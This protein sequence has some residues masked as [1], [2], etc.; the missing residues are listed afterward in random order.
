MGTG[1]IVFH[2]GLGLTAPLLTWESILLK[3]LVKVRAK[4]KG[5]L[6]VIWSGKRDSKPHFMNAFQFKQNRHCQRL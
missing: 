2:N 4:E 6:V 5:F 3:V 1:F